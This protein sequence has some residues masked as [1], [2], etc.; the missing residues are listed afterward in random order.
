MVI[1]YDNEKIKEAVAAA[2]NAI[3]TRITFYDTSSKI[4]AQTNIPR[5]EFC[6][7]LFE[8][9]KELMLCRE[10]YHKAA[11][12]RIK[13]NK[14]KEILGPCK[15]ECRWGFTDGYYSLYDNGTYVGFFQFGSY[16]TCN[17]LDKI[18]YKSDYTPQELSDLKKLFEVN[19]YYAPKTS[20]G[21][22]GLIKLLGDHF[23]KTGLIKIKFDAIIERAEGYI[24]TNID[25]KLTVD[26][27]CS[28]LSISRN[29]L[30]QKF[31]KEMGCSINE[32]IINQRMSLAANLLA[33]SPKSVGAICEEIGIPDASYFSKIF[34]NKNGISPLKYRKNNSV[35][36]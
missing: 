16:R 31:N 23:I 28:A 5:R 26:S 22:S 35:G 17:S 24:R 6:Q 15:Y 13:Q 21:I 20:D 4:I 18:K 29:T 7:K 14:N 25:K 30:Y 2:A 27:I 11:I 9:E 19:R 36:Y 34:K 33:N 1:V 12:E 32:Y 10:N 3:E 8:N